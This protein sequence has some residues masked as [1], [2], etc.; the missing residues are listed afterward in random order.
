MANFSWVH[1]HCVIEQEVCNYGIDSIVDDGQVLGGDKTTCRK[2]SESWLWILLDF[3]PPICG[4]HLVTNFCSNSV[5]GHRG[6]SELCI[7]IHLLFIYSLADS[8]VNQSKNKVNLSL[9][10]PSCLFSSSEKTVGL[11]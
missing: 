11:P 10:C 5:R 1:Q 9:S 3:F 8:V 6:M 4:P 7:L 2:G